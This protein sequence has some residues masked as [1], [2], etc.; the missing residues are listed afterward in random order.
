MQCK[1]CGAELRENAK[2]CI[3]CGKPVDIP[4]AKPA[5]EVQP[6]E[7]VH[8]QTPEQLKEEF[9]EAPSA[10]APKE[11]PD[12]FEGDKGVF[13]ND[14]DEP[15]HK[16]DSYAP[17][18]GS[19]RQAG[20]RRPQSGGQRQEA[21]FCSK[22]GTRN[23]AGAA[24]CS[25]CGQPLSTA[26]A[27]N[28]FNQ[29]IIGQQIKMLATK[30]F[31]HPYG[32]TK[33]FRKPEYRRSN[34]III[35]IKD[36]IIALF[37]ALSIAVATSGA[38]PIVNSVLRILGADP[39]GI[40]FKGIF[41]LVLFDAMLV[42]SYFFAAKIF[43]SPISLY[44]WMG[45]IASVSFWSILSLVVSFILGIVRLSFLSS[46]FSAFA[47]MMASFTILKAYINMTDLE[48]SR[49]IYSLVVASLFIFLFVLILAFIFGA[50][51]ASSAGSL[52]QSY[53]YFY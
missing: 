22:C 30:T 32:L 14:N 24:N 23:P 39:L 35:L 26:G 12:P 13:G 45:V 37:M 44:E 19:R 42:F 53:P 8:E 16:Q 9:E 25:R 2:F 17:G 3:K 1:N 6:E 31:S 38:D 43:G 5:E 20:S 27:F 34:L 7:S 4:E 18:A 50:M 10:F 52:I 51:L 46:L 29:S 47:L 21:V 15:S 36:L 48:D 49:Q 11:T 28:Q 41:F 33:E 40:F